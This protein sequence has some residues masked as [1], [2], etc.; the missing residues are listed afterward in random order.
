MTADDFIKYLDLPANARVDQRVPKKLL[1]E[2]GAPTAAD[3]KL[4]NENI[5]EVS[6]IAALQPGNV[7]VQEYRDEVREY[8]EVEVIVLSLRGASASRLAELVHR[9][10]PYPVLLVTESGNS[11]TLS[12]AHKRWSQGE[13][14]KVVLEDKVITADLPDTDETLRGEF[15]SSMG[16]GEQPQTNM[17]ALYQG[18]AGRLIA[19]KAAERT[20]QYTP[21]RNAE[22]TERQKQALDACN[23][24]EREMAMLR[25]VAK[26]ER[27]TAKL[28]EYNLE[29]KRLQA[30]LDAAR[31]NLQ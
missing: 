30:A 26:K 22:Q 24:L 8:L 27:Q 15:L 31:G 4:I 3:K 1:V 19:L 23:K 29:L 7:G 20:G 17:M 25:N 9:A 21:S 18:W 11:L 2:N 10:I 16:L 13:A 12:V 28:V 6:W 14:G 5:E